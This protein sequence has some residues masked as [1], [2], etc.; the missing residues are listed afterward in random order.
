[1]RIFLTGGTGQLGLTF[2]ESFPEYEI[3]A[4]TRNELDLL[5]TKDVKAKIAH[6]KPE[7]VINTAAWTDV[8]RA[9]SSSIEAMEINFDSVK[10]LVD[11][12]LM[13]GS[14][15]IQV[16]TDFVFDG[17]ASKPYAENGV[18]NPISNYGLSK[19][20]AEDYI[21]A[22]YRENAFI[23]RTSWLYS[24][25]R[26]NFVKS[27]LRKLLGSDSEIQ[28]VNDQFGSPTFSGDLAHALNNFCSKDLDPGIYHYANDGVTSW[29]LFA[30]EIADF[31]GFNPAR[32]IPTSTQAIEHIVKRPKF[33]ALDTT[34]YSTVIGERPP[35]WQ[36]SLKRALPKI[37]TSAESESIGEI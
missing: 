17:H 25:Y 12:A 20:M 34:K 26:S 37:R 22:T 11:S 7:I 35:S 24:S 6:F 32:I 18:K 2:L 23:I 28:V 3:S 10:N 31:S 15:F 16:S 21:N 5:N 29:Y 30:R 14:T 9:E 4:P 27:I 36:E 19:S 33:S 13:Q 1:M 8:P